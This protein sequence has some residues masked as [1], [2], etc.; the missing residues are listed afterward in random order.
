MCE[1]L[2]TSVDGVSKTKIDIALRITSKF[3]AFLYK[4]EILNNLNHFS[5]LE[6]INI[7]FTKE[8]TKAFF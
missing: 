7:K 5:L 2:H 4:Q 8:I 6:A 1:A 3:Y